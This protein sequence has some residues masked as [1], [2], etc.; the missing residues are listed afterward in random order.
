MPGWREQ[1]WTETVKFAGC[2]SATVSWKM[3]KGSIK[4]RGAAECGGYCQWV[5]HRSSQTTHCV[6]GLHVYIWVNA[7]CVWAGVKHNWRTLNHPEPELC[8]QQHQSPTCCIRL[9]HSL[10]HTQPHLPNTKHT[11]IFTLN[12]CMLVLILKAFVIHCRRSLWGR[13]AAISSTMEASSVVFVSDFA[14]LS[15]CGTTF[16]VEGQRSTSH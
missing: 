11:H 1:E 2:K 5:Q 3:L 12:V 10:W 6:S 7:Y 9:T 8:L 16:S 13:A 14:E 15:W 4:L